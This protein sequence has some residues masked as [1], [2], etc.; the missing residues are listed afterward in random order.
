MYAG[1]RLAR[2]LAAKGRSVRCAPKRGTV[3]ELK[4]VRCGGTDF[5]VPT[6]F[7]ND[8]KNRGRWDGYLI[9]T[10]GQAYKPEATRTKR[11][12]V[13]GSGTKLNFDSQELQIFM[14]KNQKVTGAWR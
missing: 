11:G 8:P 6:R 5:N 1:L 10:D 4:R 7:V 9:M 13:L 3:P 12:W 14:S 2:A